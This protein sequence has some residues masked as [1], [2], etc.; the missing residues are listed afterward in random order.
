MN[1]I[2]VVIVSILL[3]V[4]IS[5]SYYEN[6]KTEVFLT[7]KVVVFDVE[8]I[9]QNVNN[10]EDII[11][12]SSKSIGT[13]TFVKPNGEFAALGH[14]ISDI[15]FS[16]EG[17]CYEATF[18][19]I[20]K[21]TPNN[22]GTIVAGIRERSKI[23][24]VSNQSYCGVFGTVDKISSHDS[25]KIETANR[26]TVEKGQ[27]YLL[28]NFDGKGIEEYEVEIT[29]VNFLSRTKNITITVKSPELLAKTGGI[30]QGMSGTPIVQ[31]GRLIGAINCVNVYN[32]TEAYGI[33]VD[34]LL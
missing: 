8:N 21:S 17:E 34:K 30:V 24:D 26:Y 10:N 3:L 12:V 1:K 31:N 28:I 23:G 15:N 18:N 2:L 22:P 33:F 6:T 11:Y 9:S 20:K 25:I 13:L 16:V 7:G 14:S 4:A 29:R 32:P 27:A 5:Y 19:S